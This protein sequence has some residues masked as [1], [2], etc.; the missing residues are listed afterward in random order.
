MAL[1]EAAPDVVHINHLLDHSPQIMEITRRL[2]TALILTLHD[3]YFACPRII[4]QQPDGKQCAG[5]QAGAECIRTCF[6]GCNRSTARTLEWRSLYF[7]RLLTLPQYVLCP[8]SYV[9]D[10]FRKWRINAERIVVAPNGIVLPT[11]PPAETARSG[12]SLRLAYMGSIIRHKGLHVV[13][14]ALAQAKVGG[15]EFHVNG[16]AEPHYA[17][18]LR[19]QAENVP[20]LQLHFHGPYRPED[21]GERLVG[22]DCVVAPSQWA[23]TF[24]LVARES[25]GFGIPVV[26][27]RL[28][29]LREAIQENVNGLSFD[30]DQPEQLAAIFRRFVDDPTLLPRLRQGARETPLLG[31]A[32]H[33]AIVRDYYHRAIVEL[34]SAP[35]HADPDTAELKFLYRSLADPSPA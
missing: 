19:R 21:L 27:S 3:F 12:G 18:E 26:V 34:A 15:V 28:G 10:Y 35:P 23:E 14:A 5:P 7:R 13:I 8:S 20:G 2:R 32:R 9:A 16:P 4:L 22:I 31:A 24:L 25:M 11:A 6:A 1:V 30:H 17:Q 33:A 29:A